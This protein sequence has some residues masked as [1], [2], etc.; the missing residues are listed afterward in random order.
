MVADLSFEIADNKDLE[1][2]NN[3][4]KENELCVDDI[5]SENIV[6]KL[7]KSENELIAIYGFELFGQNGIL[8]S[9]AVAD[10][11]KGAGIGTQIMK[12]VERDV[13]ELELRNLFLLTTT[14]K[15]FFEKFGFS[16]IE[17]ETAPVVLQQSY[18]FLTF[19]P[20]TAIVM[21]KNYTV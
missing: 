9:V 10:E 2:I 20:D 15:K 8:R 3:I 21:S 13:K 12:Q 16:I 4:L 7:V 11:Y 5:P 18:E 19:C 17:R 6:L 14:A 1:W